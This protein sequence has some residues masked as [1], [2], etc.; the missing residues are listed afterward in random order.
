MEHLAGIAV[1][2]LADK[3]RRLAGRANKAAATAEDANRGVNDK[4][5]HGQTRSGCWD[6]SE[7]RPKRQASTIPSSHSTC[8]SPA[9]VTDGIRLAR[10]AGARVPLVPPLLTSANVAC[11]PRVDAPRKCWGT[12]GAA[13][14]AIV[15]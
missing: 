4:I 9:R 3:S 15:R 8:G 2:V 1:H 6:S 12:A 10:C 11:R 7:D 13:H 5:G 14:P